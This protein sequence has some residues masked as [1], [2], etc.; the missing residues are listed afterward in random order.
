MEAPQYPVGPAPAGDLFTPAQREEFIAQIEK[1]PGNLRTALAGL[2]DAQ[3][4]TKYKNWTIR[5]IANHLADSHLNSLVRF[6]WTL[7]EETPSIKAYDDGA[8]SKLPDAVSGELGPALLLLEG[9]HQKWVRLLRAMTEEQFSRSFIHPDGR[10]I[11]LSRA[12]CIYSW[13][14]R[15]HTG[16]VLW[17]RDEKGWG[18]PAL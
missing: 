11:S 3:L 4:D 8:W 7:T 10:K 5:Q 12:L 18:K 1:A 2:N 14:C 9:I 15:H 13:H 17:L 16:Q 6:K